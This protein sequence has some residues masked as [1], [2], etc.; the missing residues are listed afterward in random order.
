VP[1]CRILPADAAKDQRP[2]V[3]QVFYSATGLVG[4][5]RHAV[6]PDEP[7]SRGRERNYAAANAFALAKTTKHR[8]RIGGAARN[9]QRV[10]LGASTH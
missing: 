1:L 10:D 9:I 3:L 5:R 2:R 6:A 4:G 7:G 8:L